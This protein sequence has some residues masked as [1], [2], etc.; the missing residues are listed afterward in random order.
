MGYRERE[1]GVGRHSV[2]GVLVNIIMCVTYCVHMGKTNRY[3]NSHQLT[4][5]TEKSAFLF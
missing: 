3:F 1:R 5:G 4:L 2:W